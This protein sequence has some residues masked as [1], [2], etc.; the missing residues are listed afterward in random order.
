MHTKT[1]YVERQ[2]AIDLRYESIHHFHNAHSLIS[3]L[4]T[5]C[6]PNKLWGQRK[7][8]TK[9]KQFNFLLKL[10]RNRNIWSRVFSSFHTF[11]ACFYFSEL[12][13]LTQ[14][15]KYFTFCH[16]SICNCLPSVLSRYLVQQI[17]LFHLNGQAI[18]SKQI[19]FKNETYTFH[20]IFHSS[21]YV[22]HMRSASM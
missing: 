14:N 17:V 9:G 21:Q 19:L 22:I 1:V 8:T 13:E 16:T 2:V 10:H 3:R 11:I 20:S 15:L 7:C 18:L 12:M 5:F 6:Y 4:L